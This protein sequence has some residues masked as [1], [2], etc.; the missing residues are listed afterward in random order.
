[1]LTGQ[2]LDNIILNIIVI[3]G[4]ISVFKLMGEIR[5]FLLLLHR[6]SI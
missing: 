5:S 4:K 6:N 2:R 3:I 1:M